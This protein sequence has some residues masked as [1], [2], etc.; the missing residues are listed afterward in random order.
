M[1]CSIWVKGDFGSR[2][3]AEVGFSGVAVRL[4]E[5]ILGRFGVDEGVVMEVVEA[6]VVGW[7]GAEVDLVV[8]GVVCCAAQAGSS[9]QLRW[10][11]GIRPF[12]SVAL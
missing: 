9:G 5:C 11:L 1:V 3:L 7:D 6:E 10:W 2:T 4:G 8:A 12:A